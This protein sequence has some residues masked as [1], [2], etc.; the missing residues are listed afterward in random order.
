[1]TIPAT[2]LAQLRDEGPR[3]FSRWDAAVFDAVVSGPVLAL[4]ERLAGQPDAHSVITGYLNL[5][6]QGVGSG[7]VKHAV[8]GATGWSSFLERLVV[9]LMPARLPEIAPERQLRVLVDAWNLGEGLLREP[10]WVDRYVNACANALPR[11]DALEDFL[12]RTLGPVLTPAPP[13]TWTGTLKV[14]I[15][16]LRPAH[17]EFLPG[18]MHLAAPTV[19]C[20]EDRRRAGLQVGVFLRRGQKSEPLGI[21]SGLGE[22]AESGRL[23]GVEIIDGKAKIGG[24]IADVPTLRRCHGFTVARAGFIAACAPDSQHLWVI[25]SE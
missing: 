12:V 1:M 15:L 6:Q 20:V 18:K 16:D 7:V 5:V 19:L 17:D 21:V 22:Y 4:A 24:R 11:L 13:A 8:P 9:E 25:E 14:A 2:T 10:V 3:R 23:P